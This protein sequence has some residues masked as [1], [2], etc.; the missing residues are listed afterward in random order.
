MIA[1]TRLI[2]EGVAPEL[3]DQMALTL[4]AVSTL[5]NEEARFAAYYR[6]N[7]DLNSVSF[8]E[9]RAADEVALSIELMRR[10][11]GYQ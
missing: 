9:Q 6:A 10:L 4:Q 5:D 3:A 11:A 2:Q 1:A 7:V 8:K